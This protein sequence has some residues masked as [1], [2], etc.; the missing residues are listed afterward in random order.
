MFPGTTRRWS[1]TPAQSSCDSTTQKLYP[2]RVTS[3]LAPGLLVAAPPLGD[4]NFDRS[5]V[6]LAAHGPEGAF[7]W[8]INGRD[9]MTLPELLVRAE[10][11]SEHL[12]PHGAVHGAVLF[13][14]VDTAMGAATM[15]VLGP[16]QWCASIDVQLRFCKPVFEGVLLGTANVVQ[17]GKRIVHLKAEIHDQS[18]DLV[19]L[20]TG[21]FAVI[22]KPV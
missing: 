20:A 22:P 4:P 13:A 2:R 21:S 16:D 6:L 9:V 12:N 10:V 7:G 8:I 11:T 5:V 14:M 18:Q 3:V 17:A 15:S 1:A 19:G